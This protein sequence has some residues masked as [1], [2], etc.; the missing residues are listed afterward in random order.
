MLD[1]AVVKVVIAKHE[2]DRTGE[3]IVHLVQELSNVFSRTNVAAEK[4]KIRRLRTHTVV[5]GIS[6]SV[7]DKLKVNIRCPDEAIHAMA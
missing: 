1:R 2:E 5:E 6:A 7:I 3:R 4:C